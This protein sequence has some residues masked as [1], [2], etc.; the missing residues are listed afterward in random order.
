MHAQVSPQHHPAVARL[1]ALL[2]REH[3]LLD[4]ADREFYSSDIYNSDR[5][6]LA[7]VRPATTADVSQI[8]QIARAHDLPVVPRGGGASYTD[9][10]VPAEDNALLI[11]TSRMNRIVEVNTRDM[12]VVAQVGVTW[13]ALNEALRA[14][15]LRTPFFGPFSGIAATLGG[16]LSQGAVTWGTGVF[17][18]SGE[19]VLGVEVV[20]GN[21]EV[22][23]TGSWGAA[24]SVP[25]LR[26]Y[27]PDLTGLFMSDAG[28]LGIKA[29]VALRLMPRREHVLG[30]SFGFKDFESMAAGME[31]AAKEG[32]NLT[33]FGLD[34]QL[35]Q[36]Q[37]GKADVA[38]GMQA[39][40][41]VFK[42]SRGFFDGVKQVA[43][44]GLAGRGFLKGATFSAHWL[45]DGVD[46]D[47]VRAHAGKLREV[48]QP[49][50]A[51]VP[52]TVPTVANAMPFMPLYNVR[53]PKG[54]RWVPIHGMLPFSRVLDFRRDLTAYYAQNLERMQRHHITYGAMFMTVGTNAFLYE[55]V[56]YWHDVQ[57]LTHQRLVPA[58]YLST[59]PKYADNPEGRKIV[60]EMKHGIADLFQK[61]GAAH[62][63]IGKFYP[64]MRGR[65]PQTA[66]LIRDLKA[67]MDPKRSLN[68]GAL[69]L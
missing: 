53:G 18:I 49:F 7:V 50:G 54:E 40:A 25:F 51:E 4:A 27:G 60:N 52:A 65:D 55:P 43:K 3:V 29:T 48:I 45:V 15:G 21:G 69:G 47:A 33:N 44:I 26:L 19:N 36:G 10:Y 46:D 59:L 30:L 66:K 2:G 56:F 37:L 64:Y 20:L 42:T 32:L 16:A 13:A 61:H 68:P 28:A 23:R 67:L 17:G 63:Q 14:H 22:V 31:A 38:T 34:P 1:Q 62:M 35:Q 57:T 8:V 41:A 39:A 6:A 12:Y 9:G 5:V 24:N 58:D 11:D